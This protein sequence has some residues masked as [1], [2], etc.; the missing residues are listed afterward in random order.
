VLDR[1]RI[2]AT[3]AVMIPWILGNCY[4]KCNLSF[5]MAAARSVILAQGTSSPR[6]RK[7]LQH[8]ADGVFGK[9]TR[10]D[11]TLAPERYFAAGRH[12][13]GG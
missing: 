10:F 13:H 1:Q 5:A 8:N 4:P 9:D 3:R 11:Q 7:S 2:A 6:R 12:S